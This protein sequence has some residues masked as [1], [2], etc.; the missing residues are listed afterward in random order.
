[1]QIF[2]N[3]F[4]IALIKKNFQIKLLILYKLNQAIRMMDIFYIV[5]EYKTI[6]KKFF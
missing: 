6:E 3:P 4:K 5:F 2:K 1:M